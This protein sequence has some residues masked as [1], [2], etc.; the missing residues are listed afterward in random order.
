MFIY[1]FGIIENKQVFVRISL[2]KEHH[3]K[4]RFFNRTDS[5]DTKETELQSSACSQGLFG[6]SICVAISFDGNSNPSNEIPGVQ[7]SETRGVTG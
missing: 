1:V 5:G 2:F 3:C 7:F 4:I 6:E